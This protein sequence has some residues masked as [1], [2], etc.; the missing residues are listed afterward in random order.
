MPIFIIKLRSK[1][2]PHFRTEREKWSEHITNADPQCC[3]CHTEEHINEIIQREEPID[4]ESIH[5]L[6]LFGD[7]SHEKSQ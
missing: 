4:E 6:V 5:A 3:L 1:K 2:R 7:S